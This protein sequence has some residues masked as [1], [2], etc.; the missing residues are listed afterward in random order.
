MITFNSFHLGG[1]MLERKFVQFIKSMKRNFTNIISKDIFLRLFFNFIVLVVTIWIYKRFNL[2]DYLDITVFT[3]AIFILLIDF[4]IVSTINF[5][6]TKMEDSRKTTDDYNKLISKYPLDEKYGYLYE[7]NNTKLNKIPHYI[8]RKFYK[9]DGNFNFYDKEVFP[10]RKL[11]SCKGKDIVLE[12]RN[13]IYRMDD[14]LLENLNIIKDVHKNSNIYNNKSIRLD[15]VTEQNG[16]IT[17]KTS[18]TTYFDFCASNRMIDYVKKNKRTIRDDHLFGPLFP[19]LEESG[20][21]NLLG[22]NCMVVSSDGYLVFIKR[23]RNVS[24][25]K[26][27]L[28][29]GIQASIKYMYTHIDENKKIIDINDIYRSIYLELQ[30]EIGVTLNNPESIGNCFLDVYYD[31]VEAKPQLYFEF[32]LNSDDKGSRLKDIEAYV[33]KKDKSMLKDGN[34]VVSI[35]LN[36]CEDIYISNFALAYKGDYYSM[37][38]SASYCVARFLENQR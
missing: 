18:R 13:E 27:K 38:P 4:F 19:T 8:R 3:A 36:K 12:D 33:S 16:K 9:D 2:E 10:I 23:G 24:I 37:V 14:D 17:L 1:P 29:V 32:Y 6:S 30:D 21:S 31:Y 22:F 35:P 20:L 28:G 26:G 25:E 15:G 34:S 11:C 5:L 7:F